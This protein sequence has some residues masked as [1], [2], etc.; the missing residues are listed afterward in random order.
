MLVTIAT[1]PTAEDA[2]RLGEASVTDLVRSTW[3]FTTGRRG[4]IVVAALLA[5]GLFALNATVPLLT[6]RL[7]D[8]ALERANAGEKAQRFVQEWLSIQDTTRQVISRDRDNGSAIDVDIMSV[9]LGVKS[10][11]AQA[12]ASRPDEYLDAL[13]PGGLQYDM[14]GLL[15]QRL[16]AQVEN[17]TDTW[18]KLVRER[19]ADR[20]LG[21]S[22]VEALLPSNGRSID[23]DAAD[24]FS[25]LIA[26]LSLEDSATT[27]RDQWRR[28]M[29]VR[30]LTL[31]GSVVVLVAVLRIVTLRRSLRVTFDGARRLQDEVFLRVHDT[32]IVESGTLGRPSMVSRCTSYVERV[33]SAM[34]SLLTKGVPAAA[35]LAFSTVI[36][37]TIDPQIGLLMCV[38]L[39]GF[40]VF[41]RMVS[42]RWSR[43][44]RT[45]L[46]DNTRLSE[47]SDD[48]ISNITSIRAAGAEVTQRRLFSRRADAVRTAAV[49]IETFSEGFDFAAFAIAQLGVLASVA[50]I[51]FTRGSIT[52]GAAAASILYVKSMSDAIGALPGVVV[53]MQEAAPYMRRL[54]RV[55]SF[56]LR[57]DVRPVPFQSTS[58]PDTRGGLELRDASFTP[59]D[60]SAGCEGVDLTVAPGTMHFLVAPKRAV[61]A[62]VLV[63]ASGLDTPRTGR[64]TVDGTDLASL[65]LATVRTIVATVV[66]D[67]YIAD[68]T[69]DANLR[70]LRPDASSADV[71]AAVRAM[72]L[73]NWIATLPEGGA[74]PVGR[75]GSGISRENR[76]RIGLAR[77]LVSDATVIVV[78]D[79][80]LGLDQ[81]TADEL[82]GAVRALSQH[83]AVLVGTSQ[84][85]VVNGDDHVS[86]MTDSR[87]VETGVADH[88][89]QHGRYWAAL[90][91]RHTGSGDPVATLRSISALDGVPEPVLQ[92]AVRR[93]VTESFDD[94]EQVFARGEPSDRLFIVVHGTIELWDGDRRV[95]SLHDGDHFGEF[96]RSVDEASDGAR[97]LSAYARGF[98]TLQSLH[99][100]ALA[101]GP[102]QVLDGSSEERMVFR[103]LA[104]HGRLRLSELQALL[105]DVPMEACLEQMVLSGSIVKNSA[106]GDITWRIAGSTR[107]ASHGRATVL[108]TLAAS[109]PLA[110]RDVR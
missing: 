67:P 55:L 9:A 106:D 22:D 53:S 84:L 87:V 76:I 99:R 41:R 54:D 95:A 30:D 14:T 92:R 107:S 29:F 97:P 83:R 100:R 64:V 109:E 52:L 45:K 56:P 78:D 47:V 74:T 58:T 42:P 61:R 88:L 70:L 28:S 91:A 36:L 66:A 69:L 60:G 33:Q 89:L 48:A 80:I 110:E 63:L 104:R 105:P 49:R 3:R 51:G 57:R 108:D 24:A 19:L 68:D 50:V 79:P 20:R 15:G 65:D 86:V 98:V 102:A 46:D 8:T 10:A 85:A 39:A 59:P 40:E 44:V 7:L 90:W 2:A 34:T 16:R 82:W 71:D 93:M 31:V 25:F 94:G 72:G 32:T 17:S 1:M 26:G 62:A 96:D 38:L 75:T 73:T 37:I 4:S 35:N 103:A 13:F 43:Q 12:V 5:V 81:E 6:G 23:Q 11:A 27:Q 101:G 18:V 77:A 21:R